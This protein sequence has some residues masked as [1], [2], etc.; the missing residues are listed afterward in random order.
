MS[1]NRSQLVL[2]MNT[3]WSQTTR[4][5]FVVRRHLP[6]TP[7][8]LY[9]RTRGRSHARALTAVGAVLIILGSLFVTASQPV[10]TSAATSNNLNFQAR[11]EQ[12]N[13]S[14][15]PDGNYNIQ[16]KLYG[17][18]TAG[19]AL[20]TESYLNSVGQGV[21]VV[22]GY[23]SVNLGSVTAFPSTMSWDQEMWVTMNIG[24][25]STGAPTYD[26]EMSPRLK[27]TAV[28]YAFQAKSATQ[29]QVQN[30]ANV[31]TLS[32]T[33]PTANRTIALPNDSG[34]V[35]LEFSTS[36]GFASSAGSNAYI[37]NGTILQTAANFNFQS[38]STTAIS[39]VIQA[40]TGQTADLLRFNNA[41]GTAALSGFNS[42]GRLYYQTGAF[43]GTLAQGTLAQSTVYNLI[44][45]GIASVDLC[46]STGNCAGAGGGVTSATGGTVNYLA[47]FDAIRN[48][49]DST[50]FD[51]GSFVG[52]GTTTNNGK[53]SVVS[54]NA[55][56]SG[57]FVKAAANA[58]S[59]AFVVEGGATPGIGGDL[60]NLRSSA[61]TVLSGFDS[62]GNL[63]FS[64]GFRGTVSQQPL[65]QATTYRLID[66]SQASVDICLSTGNCAGAGSSVT[67][68]GGTINYIAK[69]DAARSI[70]NSSLYNDGAFVGLNTTTNSGL[71]SLVGA[72]ATQST[73]FASGFANA[74]VPTAVIRGG[75]TPGLGGDLLQLQNSTN[76]V[77]S[78]IDAF[79]NLTAVGGVF[80]GN[81]SQTGAGT[82]ST[83]TGA[84]SLNGNTSVTGAGT[85]TVGTGAA[86]LGG[87][88]TVTGP[89]TFNGGLTAVGSTL[90]NTTGTDST[91]IGNA[92]GSFSLTSSGLNISASGALSGVTGYAQNGGNFA[93]NGVGTLSTGT[94]AVT[95]NG[96]TTV[97]S[98]LAVRGA[99][100]L[101][102][103]Q[104]NATAG[105]LNFA[106]APG[107]GLS[108]IRSLAP[109]SA[110]NSTFNLPSI[111]GSSTVEICV[112]TGTVSYTHLTLPTN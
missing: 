101:T 15:A 39:G 16:F 108:I 111:A 18:S 55:S 9:T 13:G 7:V 97:T 23:V 94:G 66:P 37:Q 22:N 80:S 91:A 31:A 88:L 52:I 29:L 5:F 92:S 79:G 54:S 84:V 89:A 75:A 19:T 20:W 11:L 74:T 12:S 103:G 106:N 8:I 93:I 48:I 27:L 100:G 58:T 72:S 42:A 40:L 2:F 46:L 61:G 38:G 110:G 102:L 83:G 67:S 50:L 17:V 76:A 21:R 98:T 62:N 57:I 81:V 85:L 24:G 35:C 59:A 41:A 53:L 82:L 26:G 65:A 43:T 70:A 33:A 36:C 25:T 95:L 71:L 4:V 28:P 51:N 99:G 3:L 14:I 10:I 44:D 1:K 96:A 105:V 30:G 73:L 87:T 112:S 60:I 45:P 69:F 34:T 56:Q 109:S 49:V 6:V 86:A 90:I 68:L 77:V 32:F 107:A 47:K 78:K 104:P 64:N 63:F